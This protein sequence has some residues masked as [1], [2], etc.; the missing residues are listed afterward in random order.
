[1][2]VPERPEFL[3]FDIRDGL[4]GA[5]FRH[6]ASFRSASGEMFLGGQRG[7]NFFFPKDVQR[8]PHVPR[9]VLTDLKIF[10]RPVGIGA[11]GSPLTTAIT[12]ARALT[13][14]HKHSVVTFEFSA[15]DFVLPSKNQYRFKLEGFDADWNRV[16]SRRTATYTN[17]PPGSYTFRVA[18]SNNDGVW[19][20]DGVALALHVKPP[21]WRTG[22]F[23]AALALALMGL[24][25]G[26]HRYRIRNHL[27][28]ERELQTRVREAVAQIRTLSGLLPICAWCKKVRD[29]TGYWKQ[30]ETYVKDHS[31]ADFSHGI[32]PECHKKVRGE[33][34]VRPQA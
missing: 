14:S 27:R 7:L 10:N 17:L 13:L 24:A 16:G 3:N 6:G 31:Q 26:I 2:R 1:V 11:P 23:R 19:N 28:A 22:L 32:C 15:L 12:E 30:L 5:E 25:V 8:N 29:D 9:V 21:F 33:S 34:A 4:Q 20:E 18:G